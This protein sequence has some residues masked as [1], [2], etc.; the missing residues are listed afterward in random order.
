MT[1][2]PYRRGLVASAACIFLLFTGCG[3]GGSE[4]TED[5]VAN[6]APEGSVESPVASKAVSIGPASTVIINEVMAANFFGVTDEDT[7]VEDWVELY[8]TSAAAVDLSGW[9]L[10]NKPASPFRWVFPTGTSLASKG[11]LRVWLS[12][13]DRVASRTNLHANFN[14]DNGAD[15][16]LLSAPSGTVTGVLRDRVVVPLTRQDVSLC[17][18]PN[19]SAA[20]SFQHCSSPTPSA[21]NSGTAAGAMLAKPAISVASGIYAT[22]Q[23][24]TLTGPVGAQLRYSLNGSEPTATSTL[25][26]AP[27]AIAANT[28]LRVAAFQTGWVTSPV[29][30]ATYV[31]DTAGKFTAQR[32]LFVTMSPSDM[33]N[34]KAGG[35]PAKGW[36]AH[37]ALL[38]PGTGTL[39]FNGNAQGSDSGQIGSRNGQNNIPLDIKFKDALGV[40]DVTAPG[41]FSTKPTVSSFKH[42]KLRNGGDDYWYAHIRDNFWQ[43]LLDEKTAPG[44]ATEPV[45][46]FTNGSYYGMMDL[47]EKEDETLIQS[48]YGVDKD[49]VQYY[50]DSK[51]LGGFNTVADYTAM[52]NF[53]VN[54]PMA[55]AAN[56]AKAQ[57]YLDVENFAQ[58]FALHMFAADRD[59]LWR[60]MHRFAMPEYD[61][62]W[63]FRPHDFDISSGGNNAWGFV[64]TVDTNMN[65]NYGN[66][67][68][69]AI[70]NSLLRN[71]EFRS[72]YI[73]VVAD[74]LNSTLSPLSTN[75]LLDRMADSMQPYMGVHWS[76]FT[77]TRGGSLTQWIN[78]IA[79][80]RNFLNQRETYY[81]QHT[82]TQFALTARKTLNVS[83][84]DTTMGTVKVNT[85]TLGNRLSATSPSWTG[86]YYPEVPVKLEARPAPGHIFVGWQGATSGT[87][88]GILASVATDGL[89]YQAVFAPA[90]AVAAPVVTSP[91]AQTVQ[92][93]DLVTLDLVASDPV[94]HKLSYS[95]K[96]LP[97]GLNLH[98]D[99]GRV[100]GKPT[101]GGAFASTITVTNGKTS[102]TI[103][104][105]WQVNNKGDR[106]ATLPQDIV[107]DGTGLAASYFPNST[108]TGTPLITR[109]ELPAL[110]YGAG[111]G[112]GQG[113]ATSNWSVRWDGYLESPI[114]GAHTLKAVVNSNDS[115]RVYVGGTL[116]IDNW[117]QPSTVARQTG[118]YTL[119]AHTKTPVRIE[120]MDPTAAANLQMQWQL[121]GSTALTAMPLAVWSTTP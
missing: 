110:A 29:E 102:T 46:V 21:A 54:N 89:S 104:L 72:L 84:N 33:S 81:D 51:V 59:W 45:Q 117:S 71:P 25:Y 9:G 107:G 20:S 55:T 17:R 44:A 116:V 74:Q 92:T 82:R 109:T 26:T 68:G 106:V 65:N 78:S 114:A 90:A 120:F 14:L 96:K 52:R 77:G 38:S 41:L 115:V 12:K 22:A 121:P 118:A 6:T 18:M 79:T 47:R 113:F 75:A 100:F 42:L 67:D 4:A 85:I 5:S 64:T 15:E 119:A 111:V 98:P 61:G 34:Y 103:N 60:N 50:N 28:V 3:G 8:N 49:F 53:I 39:L 48:T 30:T 95:A 27:V 88:A 10:S 16:V 56:Y 7:D 76:S 99:T 58:D 63:R 86:R 31:I 37:V 69:G 43:A 40:K 66:Y 11:Y 80:L 57:T 83:V 101:K 105:P 93:G 1:A 19:G 91:A 32:S 24:V 97:S 62:R 23:S 13:K 36:A 108:L 70:M 87:T 73:S 2:L 112:P 94:G 35:R